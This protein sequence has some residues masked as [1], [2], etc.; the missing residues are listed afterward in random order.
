M[1]NQIPAQTSTDTNTHHTPQPSTP[2][3]H[4]GSDCPWMRKGKMGGGEQKIDWERKMGMMEDRI[5]L[6]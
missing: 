1:S 5:P 6:T 3:K 2:I 4:A